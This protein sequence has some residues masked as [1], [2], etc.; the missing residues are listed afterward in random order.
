MKFLN[1]SM[2]KEAVSE[3]NKQNICENN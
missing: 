1:A 2:L 3:V